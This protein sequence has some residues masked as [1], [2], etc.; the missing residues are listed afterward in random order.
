VPCILY[1]FDIIPT[2]VALLSGPFVG[3]TSLKF[4]RVGAIILSRA[5]GKHICKKLFT[6]KTAF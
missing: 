5:Y 4:K 3:K 6:K 1:S 2:N